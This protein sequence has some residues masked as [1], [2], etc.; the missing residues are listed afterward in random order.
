MKLRDLSQL[1]R[2][3]EIPKFNL[4]NDYVEKSVEIT[5][6]KNLEKGTYSFKVVAKNKYN[7]DMKHDNFFVNKK[8]IIFKID[9]KIAVNT[10]TKQFL[11]KIII[12]LLLVLSVVGI[13]VFIKKRL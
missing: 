7:E 3:K 1:A 11:P 4:K 5:L 9:E 6:P 12:R 8:D 13:I 2:K 10:V